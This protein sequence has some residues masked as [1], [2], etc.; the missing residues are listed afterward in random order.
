MSGGVNVAIVGATGLVGQTLLSI[1]AQKKFPIKQL[2]LL[3]SARSVGQAYQY[4]DQTYLVQDLSDFDFKQ[5]DIAFFSA[6]GSVSEAYVP[7]AV[8]EQC[9]VIDNT[10]VYRLDPDVP[11]VVPEVNPQEILNW[12]KKGIIANPNCSTIQMVVALNPLHRE[13]QITR[14]NVATYQAVSG[15]G[16]RAV[17][18]LNA[19]MKNETSPPNIFSL[20]IAGNVIAH[21]DAF[22]DNGYT[23]EEMKMVWETKKILNDDSIQVNPTAVRVPVKTGHSEA[24]HIETKRKLTADKAL[25]L[26]STSPGIQVIDRHEAK[27]YP[28]PLCDAQGHDAVYVGRVREDIS[29]P[30]GLN[31]WVVADNIRKGAALN[32]IQIA[33]H[34]LAMREEGKFD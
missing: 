18:E 16:A 5:A 22:Q 24:I 12:R 32:S 10:S 20:P 11:L 30:L 29:H 33:Q 34:W 31:L 7:K 6:G 26:L 25:A 21:I 9:L 19:Q 8:M 27:G 23:K 15:A 2:F 3:A 4:E 14:I 13:A 17:D 1:L 28:S